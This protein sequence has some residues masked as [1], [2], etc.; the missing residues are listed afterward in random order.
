[1][2]GSAGVSKQAFYPSLAVLLLVLGACGPSLST[3]TPTWPLYATPVT[4]LDGIPIF[5]GE[6]TFNEFNNRGFTQ[7]YIVA[8][9]SEDL[10]ITT[11]GGVSGTFV[12]TYE[13]PPISIPVFR[14]ILFFQVQAMYV[15]SQQ[16]DIALEPL[17]NV[18]PLVSEQSDERSA[19][20]VLDTRFQ[21]PPLV[22]N[23]DEEL[24]LQN[25][26]LTLT[27]VRMYRSD[28]ALYVQVF[29]GDAD[30]Y[31]DKPQIAFDQEPQRIT[32]RFGYYGVLSEDTLKGGRVLEP[33][34]REF[35]Y[36]TWLK[37][38]VAW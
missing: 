26:E 9:S 22:T 27:W 3:P 17:S 12:T 34:D 2:I 20:F 28:Q 5:V 8:W 30:R 24:S 32:A 15:E 11:D 16:G 23:F 1:V 37:E 10:R 18:I 25:L 21:L 36:Y 35:E 6:M 13:G 7:Q 31:P 29:A 33:A 38:N 4:S 19:K 14:D